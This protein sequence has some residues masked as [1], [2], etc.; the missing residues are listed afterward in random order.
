MSHVE[1][2]AFKCRGTLHVLKTW[3]LKPV[4]LKRLQ[5]PLE[6]PNITLEQHS[7]ACFPWDLCVQ[8]ITTGSYPFQPLPFCLNRRGTHS[9]TASAKRFCNWSRDLIRRAQSHIY[10]QITVSPFLHMRTRYLVHAIHNV[11]W[12]LKIVRD[13][14]SRMVS[15][16]ISICW[17]MK[18]EVTYKLITANKTRVLPCVF[19]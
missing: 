11:P 14:S 8:C 4:L 9:W 18:K 15:K 6:K 17:L 19:W 13:M 10:C 3:S 16:V 1:T 2:A 12:F 7:C 5:E